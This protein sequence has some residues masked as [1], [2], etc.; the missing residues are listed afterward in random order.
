MFPKSEIFLHFWRLANSVSL[1]KYPF[2]KRTILLKWKTNFCQ[3]FTNQ[4]RTSQNK[5]HFLR[6]KYPRMDLVCIWSL[7]SCSMNPCIRF[8]T[9]FQR[10]LKKIC[11][12][13]FQMLFKKQ[14]TPGLIRNSLLFHKISTKESKQ[15][16]SFNI[17]FLLS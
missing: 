5:E 15:K 17:T 10:E 9:R 4:R 7:Y 2:I 13:M 14:F 12:W 1:P 11:G 3:T 6:T 16:K 8:S